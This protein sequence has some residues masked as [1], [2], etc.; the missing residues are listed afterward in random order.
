MRKFI[1]ILSSAAAILGTAAMA[2]TGAAAEIQ[3]PAMTQEQAN[4]WLN[5]SVYS[6]DAKKL[7]EVTS[8]QRDTAG[9][10]TE[11]YAD[12]GGFLGIG[13]TRVRVEPAQFRLVN[14]RVVLEMTAEQAKSLPHIAK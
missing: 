11:L 13:E 2:Q 12:I 5:K 4:S 7:G 1:A 14:D 9:K 3:P 6:S 10:V 8:I